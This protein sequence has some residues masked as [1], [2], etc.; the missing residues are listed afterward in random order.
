MGVSG[1][2]AGAAADD[3][4][5]GPRRGARAAA[6]RDQQLRQE[7]RRRRRW[8]AAGSTA[9]VLT[10]AAGALAASRSHTPVPAASR[11]ILPAAVSGATTVQRP[12]RRVADTSAIPGVTAWDVSA[13]AQHQHVTGPVRYAVTPPVGGPHHAVWMNA[14][15]YTAPIP[16]ERAVHN[17]EHGAVWI[18]YDPHLP[19]AARHTLTQLVARQTLIPEPQ[20]PGQANRYIDLS[21]W[22]TSTLP[23]PIVISSWGHQLCLKTPTD[24]RLKRFID[25]FR[26]SPR[27][28]PEYRNAVDGIPTRIG[29]VPAA[30]RGTRPNPAGTGTGPGM[31]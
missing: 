2:G 10:V 3:G 17:L 8:V 23:A 25:A 12:P 18:T 14:G 27:Y 13:A 4:G 5:A 6:L 21:P 31:S 15:V 1:H 16:A 30:D 19:A 24:P 11:Q 28:S 26:C 20:L 29:G 9:V 22:P 7:R